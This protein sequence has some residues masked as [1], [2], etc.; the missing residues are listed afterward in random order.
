MQAAFTKKNWHLTL[1]SP[2][3]C[4]GIPNLSLKKHVFLGKG[5]N[6][7]AIMNGTVS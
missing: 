4:S 6:S 2:V 7:K 5:N 3:V 1:C